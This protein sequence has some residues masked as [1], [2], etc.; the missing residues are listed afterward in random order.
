MQPQ[1]FT[2]H[3]PA[4]A[5]GQKTRK[6]LGQHFTVSHETFAFYYG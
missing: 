5:T 6:Q 2:A 1:D 4:T 3:I